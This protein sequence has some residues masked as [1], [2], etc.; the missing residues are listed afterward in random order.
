MNIFHLT[1]VQPLIEKIITYL[2]SVESNLEYIMLHLAQH[3]FRRLGALGHDL[4]Y[5]SLM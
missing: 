2:S 4:L 1:N 3:S 5:L